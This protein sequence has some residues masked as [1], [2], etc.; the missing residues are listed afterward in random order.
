MIDA[1][2][3]L[4]TTATDT[5]ELRDFSKISRSELENIAVSDDCLLTEHGEVSFRDFDP[6]AGIFILKMGRMEIT[7]DTPKE[8]A[9]KKIKIVDGIEYTPDQIIFN[10]DE[11]KEDTKVY[12]GKLETDIFQKF[13]EGIEGVYTSFPDRKIKIENLDDV[14]SKT[15]EEWITELKQ[16]GIHIPDYTKSMLKNPDFAESKN[17]ENS[18]L[19]RLTVADLGFA[20]FATTDQ[21]YSFAEQFG[22]EL[23][24]AEVGPQYRLKYKNQPMNEWLRIAMKQISGSGGRPDVFDMTRDDDGLWLDYSWAKPGGEWNPNNEFVFRLRKYKA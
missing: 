4:R 12:I 13:P 16:A 14:E 6:N 23:C 5:G 15:G 11:I 2:K 17:T 20:G 19:V 22:L 1:L 18:I 7:A 10:P 9:V 3:Q 8:D 24:P 21:I